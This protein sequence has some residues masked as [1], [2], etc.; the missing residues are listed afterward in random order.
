[1]E[2][3]SEVKP[4]YSNSPLHQIREMLV[5]TLKI[6]VLPEKWDEV[7]GI[8]EYI[9]EPVQVEPGCLSCH[10]LQDVS[11]ANVIMYEETWRNQEDLERHIR[12]E[13]Y[14]RLL[15]A[16]DMASESPEIRFHTV[17]RTAGMELIHTVRGP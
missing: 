1:M 10:L 6:K 2:C 15:I 16:M 5:A 11:E 9:L 8:L 3:W 17:S 4:Q 14:R 7:V 12:S 13:R